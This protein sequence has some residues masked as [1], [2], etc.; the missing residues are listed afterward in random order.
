MEQG[1]GGEIHSA[2]PEVKEE[3]GDEGGGHGG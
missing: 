2:M 1:G 3:Q